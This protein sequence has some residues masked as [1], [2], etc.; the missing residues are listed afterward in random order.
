MNLTEAEEK[1]FQKFM[2]KQDTLFLGAPSDVQTLALNTQVEVYNGY[3]KNV[4]DSHE[5][6]DIHDLFKDYSKNLKMQP[7]YKN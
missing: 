6:F 5:K 7:G 2:P 3:Q 4:P 1:Y